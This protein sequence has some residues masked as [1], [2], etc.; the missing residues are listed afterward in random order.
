MVAYVL[1]LTKEG[2]SAAELAKIVNS[3][4]DEADF[5]LSQDA[6]RSKRLVI[7]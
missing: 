3:A 1:Y 5:D 7:G 6:S 2:Y 4:S